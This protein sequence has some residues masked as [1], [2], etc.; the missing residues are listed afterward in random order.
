MYG[1]SRRFIRYTSVAQLI[2]E[3]NKVMKTTSLLINLS[4]L[5][6]LLF[7]ACSQ[8][9]AEPAPTATPSPEQYLENAAQAMST[10]STVQFS[11][12]REGTPLVLDS[13]LGA[14]FISATGEF[15][16]PGKVHANVKAD[17]SEFVT[18]FDF[19]WLPEGVFMTNP[20]TGQYMEQPLEL[21]LNPNALFDPEVGL[22]SI[23][24]TR[25][26][27]PVLVGYEQLDG[28]ETIHLRGKTDA[29]TVKII[30]P[31]D[32]TGE[33]DLDF[34]LDAATSQ[35][36]RIQITEANGA[37]TAMDFSGYGDPVNIPSPE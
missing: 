18:A 17:I 19:L 23:L 26:E 6:L 5:L 16:A 4:M 33:F 25:I 20:L 14:N 30:A 1:E 15:E 29:E 22:S 28:Q 32:I 11:L 21:P 37:I 35:I 31:I 7:T 8:D 9:E 34:W 10:I 24:V 27:E 3:K 36:I 2:V 13:D 12:T